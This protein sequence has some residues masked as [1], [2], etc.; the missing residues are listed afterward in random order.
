MSDGW[1]MFDLKAEFNSRAD[2]QQVVFAF[3]RDGTVDTSGGPIPL[4]LVQELAQHA[5]VWAVGNQALKQ[6]AC[7]PGLDEMRAALPRWNV[8]ADP[9]G[10]TAEEIAADQQKQAHHILQKRIRLFHLGQLYPKTPVRLFVDDYQVTTSGWTHIYPADFL[11][12][13]KAFGWGR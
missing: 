1:G 2:I 13:A 4:A 8:L 6:E 9:T 3:D 11:S 7:V 5:R 12:L 10:W